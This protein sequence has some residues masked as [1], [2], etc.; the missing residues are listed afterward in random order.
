MWLSVAVWH[1]LY[2]D[3]FLFFFFNIVCYPNL[4]GKIFGGNNLIR[5]FSKSVF[6]NKFFLFRYGEKAMNI[7]KWKKL[8]HTCPPNHF[9]DHFRQSFNSFFSVLWIYCFCTI[10]SLLSAEVNNRILLFAIHLIFFRSF[11]FASFFFVIYMY[12]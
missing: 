1:C 7:S 6:T 8:S 2:N 9:R 5:F 4:N 3:L 11:F 10:N 12:P